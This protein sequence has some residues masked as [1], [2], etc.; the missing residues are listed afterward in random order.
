MSWYN[1][2]PKIK[3]PAKRIPHHRMSP[4]TERILKEL[5]ESCKDNTKKPNNNK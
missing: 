4:A 3:E 2:K 1:R 5:K